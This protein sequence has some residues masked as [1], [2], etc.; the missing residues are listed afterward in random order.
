MPI[1]RR[2][3]VAAGLLVALTVDAGL[4]LFTQVPFAGAV[5]TA[6]GD[7]ATDQT[8]P[9]EA[10][11]RLQILEPAVSV[12][13]KGNDVFKPGHEG[14]KLR[15]GD[16][17][18]TDETGFAQINYTDDSFTRLDVDTTFTIVSLTDDEGNRQIKGSL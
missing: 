9:A 2:R 8:E 1:P 16:T 14:Q 15:V 10:V 6:G 5:R 3:R 12:R 7:S 11:A 13:R 18:K 4:A 17:M